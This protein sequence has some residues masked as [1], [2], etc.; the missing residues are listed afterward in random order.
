M[1][2]VLEHSGR[3]LRSDGREVAGGRFDLCFRLHL[4]PE[5]APSVWEETH[6][7]VTARTGG[8]YSVLLGSLQT[9]DEAT[10]SE[11][12]WLGVSVCREGTAVEV[13]P[14]TPL[15]GASVRLHFEMEAL[16]ERVAAAETMSAGRFTSRENVDPEA[17]ERLLK[18]HRRLKRVERNSNG[19]GQVTRAV[20]DL[21]A[22]LGALDDE[23]GGRIVLIED[24]L[25]DIV[26][27]DGDL[28]DMQERIEA[29]ERGH[30]GPMR[31]AGL[32]EL[33]ARVAA[34]E[35]YAS[36][37]QRNLDALSR[38]LELVANQPPPKAGPGATEVLP[39]PVTV[40]RGGLHV[41]GGGIVVHDIEGRLA[42]ASKRDGPLFVNGRS[43]GDLVVGN[44]TAGSVVATGSVRAGRAAGLP[45]AV[46]IR[47]AGEGLTAGDVVVYEARKKGAAVRRAQPGET[48]F[49][50]VVER[51]AVELGDGPNLVAVSGVVAVRVGEA[52]AAGA[53]LVAGA[54]GAA[55]GGSGSGIGRALTEASSG[56][57][58]VLLHGS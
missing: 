45:S 50:V 33:E 17:R 31:L 46:A 29:L 12:R 3:L 18:V 43:G 57:V 21:Q 30:G 10:F 20:A 7:G 35:L 15:A 19:A 9:F 48:P 28:I 53:W 11:A 38:A 8:H 32:A 52:V 44:K 42:G 6:T 1:A 36:L 4:A 55:Q 13:G 54:D 26:G 41:A 51:A 34:A 25:R 14:R 22:R 40:Q 2:N 27:A 24:E 47:M 23:E 49:G 58:E 16:A 56:T 39:G 5:G 37:L